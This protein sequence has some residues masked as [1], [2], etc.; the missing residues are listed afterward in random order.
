MADPLLPASFLFRYC[1][2]CRRHDPIW[3]PQGVQ[4]G[5]E[6]RIPSFSELDLAPKLADVRVAW[7]E[8]GLALNVIV[9]GKRHAPWC[10]ESQLDESDGLHVWI[11]TR[12][13]HNVHRASRFCH[14]FVCLPTGA[15]SRRQ[16]PVIGQAPI[17]RA[18]EQAKPALNRHLHVRSEKRVDGYLLEACLE[19]EALVGFDPE[20]HPRLGFTYAVVDRER[21]A[22]VFAVGDEFRFAE[23]PSLWGTLELVR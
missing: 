3:T 22:Q 6:Y 13:V 12:D 20:E 7:S 15:G 8:Q 19:A 9:E 10:R 17:N 16:D 4:L 11:D 21:G 2:P 5:E 23:D 18:K 1:V 14:N